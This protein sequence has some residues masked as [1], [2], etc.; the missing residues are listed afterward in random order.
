MGCGGSKPETEEQR[1]PSSPT[2]NPGTAAGDAADAAFN[3]TGT[4]KNKT[5]RERRLS[6]SQQQETGARPRR[7]SIYGKTGDDNTVPSEVR[8]PC[9]TCG[10]RTMGGFEP[11][12]GGS[13]AK[14]NQDRGLALWPWRGTVDEAVFG[15]YDGHGRA[16]EKVSEFVIQNFP[17][18]LMDLLSKMEKDGSDKSDPG[19]ALSEA[20]IEVDTALAHHMDASVSGTTAVTCLVKKSHMWIANSGDSRAIIVRK[21]PDGS[22]MA[23]DLTLD[24][25]PDCPSEMKRILQ[26]GGHVT[27]AGANGSPSR[28]WHNLRG[29]AMAR[30]IGDHAAATVGVIAEPEITEYD[31]VDDDY[32]LVVASDGVWELL[33]SQQVAELIGSMKE[34][35]TPENITDVI[36]DQSSYMWKVEEGDYRDDI[37]VVVVK[38]PWITDEMEKQ[39]AAMENDAPADAAAS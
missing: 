9:S 32:A 28:V 23:V 18:T 10:C 14:I 36:V 22:F 15:V 29:L 37:T 21:R 35:R 1:Q 11:V 2:G 30:S 31:L 20:Y 19:S 27:P 4:E 7:L 17:T 34:E 8:S 12:P 5:F 33:T 26:M 39:H 13:V 6:I 24:H 25:K 16:G 3:V 38:L